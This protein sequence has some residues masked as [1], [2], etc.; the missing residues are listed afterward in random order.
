[1]N[2]IVIAN[3]FFHDV[4]TTATKQQLSIWQAYL[5]V[6]KSNTYKNLLVCLSMY[7]FFLP[8]G[9]K[10]LKCWYIMCTFC[11]RRLHSFFK[12]SF[13]QYATD[14]IYV[15]CVWIFRQ[16]SSLF[17]LLLLL[18]FIDRGQSVD[19]IFIGR[20]CE[21]WMLFTH[22]MNLMDAP[23]SMAWELQSWS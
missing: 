7:S 21:S 16:F 8:P 9:M 12:Y 11:C 6:V 19:T 17:L 2:I 23:F 4:P 1:M 3:L 22:L 18:L 15:W 10:V 13:C 20:F 14:R 5:V